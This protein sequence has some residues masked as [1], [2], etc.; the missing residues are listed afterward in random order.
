MR[1]LL[2]ENDE[3]KSCLE[4]FRSAVVWNRILSGFR[5]KYRSY[6]YFTGNVVIKKFS[7]EDIDV[8]EGFF[9]EN[10][11][12]RKS[13]SVS[14]GKFKK[15]LGA[16]RFHSVE[17]ERLL[18]IFFNEKIVSKK[19]EK[20]E[21]QRVKEVI[22]K[23]WKESLRGSYA[24]NAHERIIGIL[25]SAESDIKR[26]EKL[27]YLCADIMN[28]LPYRSSKMLYLPVF[29]AQ[30][31]GE[32]HAFDNGA[33]EGGLLYQIIT[34]DL[35]LRGIEVKSTDIFPAYRRQRS[36]LEA[37]ITLD[38]VSNYTMLYGV[39]AFKSD[40]EMH[41]GMAG[42]CSESDIVQVPLSVL[43]EL[44]RMECPGGRI[45]VV[46]NPSVFAMLCAED[47]N[48]RCAGGS[49]E[50]RDGSHGYERMRAGRESAAAYMCMNGQPRLAGLVALELLE[51]S[52]TEVYYAGD[53]DPEGLLIAQKL[54]RFY[55]G[56]FDFWHM[57]A[58]DFIESRSD[59]E[60][61]PKRL[62]MLEKITDERLLPAA[63][64]IKHYKTAGYQELISYL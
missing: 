1:N 41:R 23:K 62:K 38:D 32:P 31:T 17:P 63:E 10:Y 24:E 12:G 58:E 61:S 11:H 27:L 35:E 54:S 64:L 34:A 44:E 18:E 55:G 20:A 43:S 49:P 36:Y 60:I 8:L 57:G 30:T 48:E 37:G 59:R 29:A 39:T 47:A 2:S 21:E 15:A 33:Y 4:Y 9:A 3:E 56:K 22:V 40:G 42:F 14:A 46:E 45:Y 7:A 50:P 26:W 53:L 52:G 13:I 5:E 28:S 19:D 6:G 16:G 25:R 51:R